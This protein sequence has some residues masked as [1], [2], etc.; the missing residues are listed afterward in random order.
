M[1]VHRCT[2]RRTNLTQNHNGSILN[3]LTPYAEALMSDNYEMISASLCFSM[4]HH[5]HVH[6]DESLSRMRRVELVAT[7]LEISTPFPLTQDT[8]INTTHCD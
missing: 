4:T 8:M 3:Q 1:R 6:R 7:P 2:T 5:E